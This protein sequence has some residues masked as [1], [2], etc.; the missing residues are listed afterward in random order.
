MI[1]LKKPIAYLTNNDFDENN[2]LVNPRVPKDIPTIIMIQAK[3]CGYCTQAKPAFQD[4]AAK[5]DGTGK[6]FIATIEGDGDQ[7]GEKELASKIKKIDPSFRGYPHYIAYKNG[8]Y[9]KTHNGGRS[10]SD[11][12]KFVNTL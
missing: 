6:I 4:F 1:Y 2:N 8:K 11:L 12:E 3:F 10:M 5:F 7:V 9:L